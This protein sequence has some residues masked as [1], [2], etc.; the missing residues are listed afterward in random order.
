M[1]YSQIASSRNALRVLPAE[2]RL[3]VYCR[4]QYGVVCELVSERAVFGECGG[5]AE[6]VV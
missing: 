4:R 6:G 2:T 1:I 3:T 5:S